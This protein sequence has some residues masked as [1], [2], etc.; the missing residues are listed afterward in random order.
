VTLEARDL[1]VVRDGRTILQ[2]VSLSATG[3]RMLAVVGPSGSGKTTLLG[4]LA[5][6]VR[7]DEGSVDLDG[8]PVDGSVSQRRS[9]GF[10]LQTHA[11]L[12]VLTAAENVEIALRARGLDP[13]DARERAVLTLQE[14]GL[15][16]ALHRPVERLSGG[17]QQRVALARALSPRPSVLL[18]DE[19]TSELDVVTRDRMIDLIAARSAEGHVV[20]IATHDLEVAMRCDDRIDLRDGR[21]VPTP[22]TSP[23]RGF[24]SAVKNATRT[25]EDPTPGRPSSAV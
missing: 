9:F 19:P 4:V 16:S 7:P 18:A 8:V 20:V 14:V 10:L 12:P 25:D 13:D 11:L 15:G 22:N 6:L 2:D 23:Q 24:P 3:G 5:G 21:Q 1:R 17:Q